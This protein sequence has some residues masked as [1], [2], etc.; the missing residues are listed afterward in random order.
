[1]A[2]ERQDLLETLEPSSCWRSRPEENLDL[3][4]GEE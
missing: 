4:G 2:S 3:K 1:M